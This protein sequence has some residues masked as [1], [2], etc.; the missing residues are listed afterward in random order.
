MEH[1]L[2]IKVQH[3]REEQL[4]ISCFQPSCRKTKTKR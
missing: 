3:E 4:E 1:G 2:Y